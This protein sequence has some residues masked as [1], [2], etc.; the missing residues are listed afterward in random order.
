M[1]EQPQ[2]MPS[3]E[4]RALRALTTRCKG[5]FPPPADALEQALE[6][7]A[8]GLITIEAALRR[9]QTDDDDPTKHEDLVNEAET[10]REALGEL[11][12]RASAQT[13]APLESGLVWPRRRR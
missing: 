1:S 8:A 13:G 10:L 4:V 5:P 7:G 6:Q 11:R 9:K 12:Q 2:R 3:A